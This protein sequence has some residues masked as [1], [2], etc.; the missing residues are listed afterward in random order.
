MFELY[1]KPGCPYCSESKN[2]ITNNISDKGKYKFYEIYNEDEQTKL[3][4]KHNMQTFPQ[5]FFKVGKKKIKIG[6]NDD[7]K[8]NMPYWTQMASSILNETILYDFEI[9][10]TLFSNNK[11]HSFVTSLTKKHCKEQKKTSKKKS[12]KKSEKK[13]RIH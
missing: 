6:G 12:K 4:L 9:I 7:L 10:N 5:I 3:K 8:K 11:I 2:I 13:I 1:L